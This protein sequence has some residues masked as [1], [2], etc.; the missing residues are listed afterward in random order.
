MATDTL[1]QPTAEKIEKAGRV[2]RYDYHREETENTNLP[3]SAVMKFTGKA[4]DVSNGVKEVL[5]LLMWDSLRREGVEGSDTPELEVQPVLTP[6]NRG[7][8]MEFARTSLEMLHAECEHM[9][10]W[11]YERHTPEGRID[12]YRQ[13]MFRLKVHGQLLPTTDV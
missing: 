12:S 5:E 10:Q 2:K 3:G 4:A 6:Y 13:A 9:Q 1:N 8:L 7:V 11:A